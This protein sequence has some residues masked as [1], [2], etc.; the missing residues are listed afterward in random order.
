MKNRIVSGKEIAW[1]VVAGIFVMLGLTLM[2]FGIIG[3]H[4]NVALDDNFIKQ[5]E[6]SLVNAI[7]VPFDFR[8]WGI[9]FVLLGAI[10]TIITLNFNAKK[11][12]RE[13]ERTVRRQQR[14]NAGMDTKIEVKSA[15]KIIEE[16]P[17]PEIIEEKK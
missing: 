5:A 9:M 12:D 2:V 14:L 15:V 11:T 1:Y 4:M 10:I 16:N 6:D 8:I 7:K 13:I 17:T 3:H